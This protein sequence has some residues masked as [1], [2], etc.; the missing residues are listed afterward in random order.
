MRWTQFV[1]RLNPYFPGSIFLIEPKG[2]L[3]T[4]LLVCL[5]PYFPGSIFL[6]DIIILANDNFDLCLNPYFPGSIFLMTTSN[7]FSVLEIKPSQSL[8]SWIH[9]SHSNERAAVCLKARKTSQSLFSWIH[10]SHYAST[11]YDVQW[12]GVSI[13]IFLDP[14]FSFWR[15]PQSLGIQRMVSILIFLDPYFSYYI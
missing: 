7:R 2:L 8:F 12:L 4:S 6:I 11:D 15:E 14:Y 10:I 13:L 9:I 3:A 5:N 1:P